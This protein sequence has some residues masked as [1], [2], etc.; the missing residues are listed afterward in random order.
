MKPLNKGKLIGQKMPFKLKEIW[1]IRM[2]FNL[3]IDNK[4]RGCDLVKIKIS[5]VFNA[6]VVA[7]RAMVV[8]QKSGRP[9]QFEITTNTRDAIADWISFFGSTTVTGYR[10]GRCARID[11]L[12]G[13]PVLSGVWYQRTATHID[14]QVLARSDTPLYHWP[15]I[16]DFLAYR[17]RETHD[18]QCEY[19]ATFI[20]TSE[21]EIQA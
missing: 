15:A 7:S 16:S 20:Q 1:A 19:V 5:D 2:R 14:E 4:L 3:A 8:Q 18:A 10:I 21:F 6:G 12:E 17:I 13:N 11:T 9:V